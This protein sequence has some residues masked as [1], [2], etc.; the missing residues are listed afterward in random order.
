[1]LDAHGQFY[2]VYELNLQQSQLLSLKESGDNATL[3]TPYII[4]NIHLRTTRLYNK[5]TK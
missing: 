1:M 2:Q 4:R 3:V 5:M